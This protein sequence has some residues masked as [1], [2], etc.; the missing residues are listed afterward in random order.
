MH[1]YWLLARGDMRWLEVVA[2]IVGVVIYIFN[3]IANRDRKGQPPTPSRSAPRRLPTPEG[4]AKRAPAPGRP[5]APQK[6]DPLLAEIQK[7][8]KQSNPEKRSPGRPQPP[9]A[10]PVRVEPI[11]LR[12]GPPVGAPKTGDSVGRPLDS[13]HLDTTGFGTRASQ[14]TDDIKR[15]DA[16][17]EQHFQQTFSHKLG[18]LTDTS[19]AGD[20][21]IAPDAPTTSTVPVAV[22]PFADWL[23]LPTTKPEDLRRAIMLN[24]ILQRPEHRW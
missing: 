10:R 17:R 21:A 24:E 9:A 14:M 4:N 13:R 16:E 15:G 2:L 18:R 12:G 6:A 23:P 20:K 22:V 11:V 7:F 1:F 19:V 3:L 8:L 5:N